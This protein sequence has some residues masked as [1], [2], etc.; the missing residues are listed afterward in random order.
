MPIVLCPAWE[1]LSCGRRAVTTRSKRPGIPTHS[2]HL[3]LG[4][5]DVPL[6]TSTGSSP[7]LSTLASTGQSQVQAG[8][9]S[10]PSRCHVLSHTP[11]G[12]S[13]GAGRACTPLVS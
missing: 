5:W 7:K 11:K 9:Q 3:Y 10:T 1:G 2:P 4:G 6:S 12:S 8:R 13:P